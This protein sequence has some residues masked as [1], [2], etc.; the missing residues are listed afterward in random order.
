[1]KYSAVNVEKSSFFGTSRT[2]HILTYIFK[3]SYSAKLVVF[4]LGT[5]NVIDTYTVNSAFGDE[6]NVNDDKTVS[7]NIKNISE[8][9]QYSPYTSSYTVDIFIQKYI[10]QFDNQLNFLN[11]NKMSLVD[12]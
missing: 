8:V 9:K 2:N 4:D 11:K 6:V 1:M 7:W 3:E 10:Y 5:L 12:Q